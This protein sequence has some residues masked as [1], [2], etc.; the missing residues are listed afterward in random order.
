MFSK[1]THIFQ[2]TKKS[3]FS[4]IGKLISLMKLNEKILNFTKMLILLS[5][6]IVLI[7]SSYGFLCREI[8]ASKILKY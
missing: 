5:S 3:I 6:T 7:L 1:K 4:D 8:Q 2:K